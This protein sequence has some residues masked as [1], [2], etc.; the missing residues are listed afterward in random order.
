MRITWNMTIF[1][2]KRPK[3][4]RPDISRGLRH[5]LKV[6][7]EYMNDWQYLSLGHLEQNEFSPKV[8][9]EVSCDM[10]RDQTLRKLANW[11]RIYFV[12]IN[13]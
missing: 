11:W 10:S 4:A 2:D 12:W 3:E 6:C 13:K 9:L 1:P 7:L 5:G 8:N